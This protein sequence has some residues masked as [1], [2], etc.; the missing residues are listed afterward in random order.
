MEK[1]DLSGFWSSRVLLKLPVFNEEVLK[2]P[3]T[4]KNS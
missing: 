4:G 1:K 3:I 2:L